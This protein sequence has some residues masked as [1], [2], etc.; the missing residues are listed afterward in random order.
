MWARPFR[1][2]GVAD[3]LLGEAERQFL[4]GGHATAW[5]AVVAGNARA[6]AFYE[7]KGWA[8]EGAFDYAAATERGTVA[9]PCRRYVKPF[10][11]PR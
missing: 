2:T 8:D 5:L 3:A 9:V 4:A 1:G 6:R 7:R 11:R 10:T